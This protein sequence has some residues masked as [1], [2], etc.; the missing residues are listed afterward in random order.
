MTD[1][2][3]CCSAAVHL[4]VNC[5]VQ[6]VLT[7]FTKFSPYIHTYNSRVGPDA[8]FHACL[9]PV[10]NFSCSQSLC[11]LLSFDSRTSVTI[12]PTSSPFGLF[13]RVELLGPVSGK[14]GK[15]CCAGASGCT[16]KCCG[17]PFGREAG[18]DWSEGSACGC[19]V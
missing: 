17:G 19:K 1:T 10:I 15:L 2:G 8:H 7:G 3:G 5:Q 6:Y 12:C 18:L 13:S 4:V 9:Q 16:L 14:Q 11:D